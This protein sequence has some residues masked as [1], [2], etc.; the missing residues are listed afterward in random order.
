MINFPQISH[1]DFIAVELGS[2][3]VA[4]VFANMVHMVQLSVICSNSCNPVTVLRQLPSRT[5]DE[6]TSFAGYKAQI[7]FHIFLNDF[8]LI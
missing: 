7:R 6:H 2:V 8:F 1:L 3:S 5:Q 4:V